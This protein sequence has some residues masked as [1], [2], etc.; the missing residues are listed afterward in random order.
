[1]GGFSLNS[2]PMASE[3]VSSGPSSARAGAARSHASQIFANSRGIGEYFFHQMRQTP[4]HA[5]DFLEIRAC[6]FQQERSS[7][8]GEGHFGIDAA[9]QT[10]DGEQAFG[11][12]QEAIRHGYAQ[13]FRTAER[14]LEQ[15][16]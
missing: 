4:P 11:H 14:R 2:C 10:F 6:N 12:H 16:L 7:R 8:T 15:V 13:I 9:G 1:M 3:R 5:N